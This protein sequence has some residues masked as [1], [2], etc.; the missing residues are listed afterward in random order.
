MLEALLSPGELC[1]LLVIGFVA[2][3]IFTVCIHHLIQQA[4]SSAYNK[5]VAEDNAKAL[6]QLKKADAVLLE[7]I[8][9]V[10]FANRLRAGKF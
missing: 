10:D 4:Y 9:D 8:T 6:K 5:K 1:T 7:P 2:V 3:V